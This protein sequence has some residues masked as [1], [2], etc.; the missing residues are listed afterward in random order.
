MSGR[1]HRGQ[2]VGDVSDRTWGFVIWGSEEEGGVEAL[3]GSSVG[4]GVIRGVNKTGLKG[5][6]EILR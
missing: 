6:G 3:A 4:L 5:E 1:G 2:I